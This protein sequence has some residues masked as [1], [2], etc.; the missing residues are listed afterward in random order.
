LTRLFQRPAAPDKLLAAVITF[1]PTPPPGTLEP[2]NN[3]DTLGKPDRLR[4]RR[5][6]NPRMTRRSAARVR[7]RRC[8][9]F[10]RF[11]NIHFMP[12]NKL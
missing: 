5:V 11:P 12:K 2:L 4:R 7:D 9:F 8:R 1:S 3:W 10:Q 6:D